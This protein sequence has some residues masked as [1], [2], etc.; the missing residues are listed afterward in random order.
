LAKEEYLEVPKKE[1]RRDI[2]E[3]AHPLGHF[4][5]EATAARVREKY[6][7]RGMVKDIVSIIKL[8]KQCKEYKVARIIDHPAKASEIL[9]IFHRIG[10]ILVFGLPLTPEGYKVATFSDH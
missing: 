6:F 2:I 9:S 7:W 3:K 1:E 8:R 10:L 5:T 4:Q